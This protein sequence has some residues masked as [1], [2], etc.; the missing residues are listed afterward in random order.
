M[1]WWPQSEPEAR[2]RPA[3]PPAYGGLGLSQMRRCSLDTEIGQRDKG[4]KRGR[5]TRDGGG[6][7][8]KRMSEKDG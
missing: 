3:E 4:G 7:S 2:R 8:E 1:E 6:W 5:Q